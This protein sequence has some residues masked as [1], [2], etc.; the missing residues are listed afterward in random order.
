[1]NNTVW[2]GEAIIADALGRAPDIQL[3][4]D[5]WRLSRWR[6]FVGS[7][8][9]P[10]LP[11]PIF[12]V[13]I[14]GKPG[15]KTWDRDGWS[16]QGSFPGCA[17]I[18]PSGQTTGWLVDGELDV[19]T[20]SIGAADLH[21]EPAAERFQRMRFAFSD[22][23]AVALTRQVLGELYAPATPERD[24]YVG[25]L[26]GALRAHM[27]RAP[28]GGEVSELP[29]SAF[30]A[31]RLHQVMNAILQKPEAEHSLEAMAAQAGVTPS[32]FC[33]IFKKANGVTPHQYVMKAR[34][35]RARELLLQTDTPAAL[36]AEQLGFSSQSH[37]THAFRQF[38]GRTPSDFRRQDKVQ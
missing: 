13:H 15:V 7:Y 8:T 26:V 21:R 34:L 20:L 5:G 30:A 11:D 25:A 1:M 6:Q 22:P 27:L 28:V 38:T 4:A 31:Y 14:S 33:R 24:V 2:N 18:V 23:L 16:E 10:P 29:T 3:G 17:T 37:F 36:V 32:H 35:E 19:V 12:V 9:L